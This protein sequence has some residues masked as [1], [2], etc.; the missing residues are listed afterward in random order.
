MASTTIS[1]SLAT[2]SSSKAL[3]SHPKP[4]SIYTFKAYER[5]FSSSLL[6]TSLSIETAR[7]RPIC[8]GTAS[9]SSNGVTCSS[10]SSPL[11]SA[12]LFDCDGVLV[13]T[14][15]DGHRVSFNDT[16]K[17]V[18]ILFVFLS[19]PLFCWALK[20]REIHW[21]FL[22]LVQYW[23]VGGSKSYIWVIMGYWLFR[24]LSKSC[25]ALFIGFDGLVT[26]DSWL[27]RKIWEQ[28][29]MWICMVNCSKLA[30]EKKGIASLHWPQETTYDLDFIH[31]F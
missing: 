12:L 10:S 28:H 14:E 11:P 1:L 6:G 18:G 23:F 29:G 27:H 19:L 13:D 16:F 26:L 2:I 3:L 4:T 9:S 7:P 25:F 24:R 22:Q 30:V 8:R 15:K 5:T 31:I 20:F 17:E 21:I